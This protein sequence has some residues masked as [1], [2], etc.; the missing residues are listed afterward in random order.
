MSTI[1][2]KPEI[3]WTALEAVGT[4]LAFFL[5]FIIGLYSVYKD[6][7]LPLLEASECVIDF[8]EEYKGYA[9]IGTTIPPRPART[10]VSWRIRNKRRYLIFKRDASNIITEWWLQKEKENG[11]WK[12]S[13]KM[14]PFPYL[15]FGRD[16]PQSVYQERESLEEGK[17]LLSLR[18]SIHDKV[19]GGHEETIE[20]PA[21][22]FKLILRR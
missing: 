15:P 22:R 3:F 11:E 9:M 12:Y 10:K 4:V 6:S 17:Y 21:R 8:E 16:F 20:F 19:V 1:L 5:A 7:I 13:G 14:E 18:F 2:G